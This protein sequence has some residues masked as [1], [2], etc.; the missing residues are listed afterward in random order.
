MSSHNVYI[1]Y[2]WPTFKPLVKGEL[3]TIVNTVL[4]EKDKEFKDYYILNYN[5]YPVENVSLITDID[6]SKN[7]QPYELV[8]LDVSEIMVNK[9]FL[10]LFGI[11]VSNYGRIYKLIMV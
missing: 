5:N 4:E 7:I 3:S 2:E 8:N 6:T 10:L 1:N 9:A 11:S